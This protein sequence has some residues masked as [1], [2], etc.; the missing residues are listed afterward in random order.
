MNFKKNSLLKIGL[1]AFLLV[2][3]FS[4]SQAQIS[5]QG[6]RGLLRIQDGEIAELGDLYVSAFGSTFFEKPDGSSSL[7]KNSHLSLN[8]TYGLS[9]FLEFSGRFV[10]YQDDQQHIWGPIG[11]TELGL[12]IR[13]PFGS[14]RNVRLSF[15]NYFIL[16]TGVNHNLPYEPYTTDKFG[17]SPGAA[18]SLNLEDKFA[19]PLKLYWNAGYIDRNL[20]DHIFSA[21]NDQIYLGTGFKLLFNNTI[22]FWEYYAELF[23][24][25]S[26]EIA[27]RENYQVSTQGLS[28]LG[29]YNLILTAAFDIN[30]SKPTE[31]TFFKD[32]DLS[33]W[34]IWVGISKYFPLRKMFNEMAE[35]KRRENERKE[36]LRKQ[37][38]IKKERKAAEEELKRMQELLKKQKK[39][40]EKKKKNNE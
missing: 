13:I 8:F 12:K 18:L 14:E 27:F 6:G 33:D 26:D 25:R 40:N 10:A 20:G 16:P 32:K 4:T 21:D 15:R 19:V 38:I 30:L 5:L 36:E 17:W 35:Q 28:F 34:K 39:K 2:L 11:D 31:K 1:S 9:Q 7:A 24:N 23:S 37:Q 29:P 22:F 3:I